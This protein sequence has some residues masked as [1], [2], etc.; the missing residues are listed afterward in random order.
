MNTFIHYK[1]IESEE[2]SAQINAY[3]EQ[4]AKIEK[5]N[6]EFKNSTP[7]DFYNKLYTEIEED[8]KNEKF[9]KYFTSE[10]LKDY[11]DNIITKRADYQWLKENYDSY[12]TT[13]IELNVID[14]TK[15]DQYKSIVKLLDELRK[16]SEGEVQWITRILQTQYTYRL[17]KGL[18][19]STFKEIFYFLIK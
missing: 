10:Q 14:L 19:V 15:S 9:T 12:L 4:K 8:V 5:W 13:E 7:E 16:Y 2:N 11:I 18:D 3:N 6:T 17:S 1:G